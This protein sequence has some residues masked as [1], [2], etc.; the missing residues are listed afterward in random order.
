MWGQ[1][2]YCVCVCVCV[3]CVMCAG[4]TDGGPVSERRQD[5]NTFRIHW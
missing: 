5:T 3:I 4:G 2:V 1:G